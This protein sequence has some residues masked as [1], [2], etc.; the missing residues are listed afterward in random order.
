VDRTHGPALKEGE[1]YEGGFIVTRC[2]KAWITHPIT[3]TGNGCTWVIPEGTHAWDL[4]TSPSNAPIRPYIASLRDR[5]CATPG[6]GPCSPLSK[7]LR[8]CLCP[9]QC[10]FYLHEGH[11]SL[12]PSCPMSPQT[13]YCSPTTKLTETQQSSQSSTKNGRS[14]IST[15]AGC[16]RR[17]WMPHPCRHSS[18]GWMWLWAA[19]AGSWWPCT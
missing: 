5:D 17:L 14:L 6:A 15:R 7:K 8:H 19:W 18:P 2:W 9:A 12:Q 4:A 11:S 13:H 16:P 3:I 1:R 10:F